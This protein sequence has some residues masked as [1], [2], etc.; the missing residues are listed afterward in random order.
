MDDLQALVEF[1]VRVGAA[2]VV[3]SPCKIVR[4]RRS[5]LDPVMASLKRLY[6]ALS[7]PVKPV[8]HGMSWR[9]PGAV[10]RDHVVA[11]FLEIC[12]ARRIAAKFC[13]RNLV[14]TV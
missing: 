1:A 14:E 8:W 12:A 10:A 5:G 2:H 11:P 9:L 7:R 6:D 13:M 3:Y 4:P